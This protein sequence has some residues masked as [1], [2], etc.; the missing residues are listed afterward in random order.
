M[1]S[2]P[3]GSSVMGAPV[4]KDLASRSSNALK[5]STVTTNEE[6]APPVPE[7]MTVTSYALSP[8]CVNL[9]VEVPLGADHCLSYPQ[10]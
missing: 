2:S 6:V 5:T 1:T 10:L 4:K 3:L 7:A 9:C 8:N